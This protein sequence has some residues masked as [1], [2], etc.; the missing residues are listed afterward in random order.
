MVAKI[1]T[2]YVA[3]WLFASLLV[4]IGV[5]NLVLVHPVPGTVY[6]LLSLLYLPPVNE[7]MATRF[8]FVIPMAVKIILGI[9]ILWFTL[10]VSDL[11]EIMGL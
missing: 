7:F 5:A 4:V 10:G 3:G 9:F 2:S 6:I 1:S 8:G 11:A